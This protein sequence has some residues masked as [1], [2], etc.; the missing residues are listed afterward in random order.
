MAKTD[1]CFD[2]KF[3][4]ILNVVLFQ[5]EEYLAIKTGFIC[6]LW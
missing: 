3:K 1:L 4:S 2:K 6:R 5:P